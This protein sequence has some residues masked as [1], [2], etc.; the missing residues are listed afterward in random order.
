MQMDKAAPDPLTAIRTRIDAI[1]A[2]MHRLLLERAGVIRELIEIK[3]TSKPGAAF[4]PEREAD[5]MRRL[6]MRHEGDLPLATVEHIWREIITTFTAMQAPFGIAAA[7]AADPLALR[8]AIRFYFGFSIAVEDCASPAAAIDRVAG[9]AKDIAVVPAGA[10]G[11]WWDG[12][13]GAHAPKIFARLPFIEI[14]A[15]PADLPAYVIGPRLE[16]KALPDIQV[17]AVPAAD[18]VEAAIVSHGGR[19]T[20]RADAEVLA[21][22]PVAATLDELA[23]EAGR[24]V[25]GRHLGGFHQPIRFLAERVA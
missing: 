4:R 22:L 13:S 1:D 12:L 17:F 6:V 3:G 19:V 23:R 25:R 5:M 15:R 16:D 9:S 2:E 11:R 21:E 8:D 10:D 14:P 7:P 20:A 18:G 24:P